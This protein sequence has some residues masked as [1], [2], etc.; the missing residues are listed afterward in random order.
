MVSKSADGQAL[1][2]P[3]GVASLG[4]VIDAVQRRLVD[5]VRYLALDIARRPVVLVGPL[6]EHLTQN[7]AHHVGTK[8][9]TVSGHDYAV[10]NQHRRIFPNGNLDLGGVIA[11]AIGE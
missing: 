7:V 2:R 1:T 6:Q 4:K 9:G 8:V 11:K 5:K 10:A 3:D